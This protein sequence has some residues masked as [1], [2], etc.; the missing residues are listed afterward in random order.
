MAGALSGWVFG[1]A[2]LAGIWAGLRV[3]P[4]SGAAA[5]GAVASG[6]AAPRLT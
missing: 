2:C 6:V 4:A 1:A 3:A 5:S